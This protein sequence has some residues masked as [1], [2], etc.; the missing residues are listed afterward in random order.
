MFERRVPPAKRIAKNVSSNTVNSDAT[1]VEQQK[2]P[3]KGIVKNISSITVSSCATVQ[4]AAEE[5]IVSEPQ[6]AFKYLKFS[7][8]RRFRGQKWATFGPKMCW[9]CLRVFFFLHQPFKLM[10]YANICPV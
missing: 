8:K 2:P 5:A 4:A 1:V 6:N 7:Q 9:D 3:A 10:K